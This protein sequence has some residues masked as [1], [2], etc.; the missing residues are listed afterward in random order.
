[1]LLWQFYFCI[2]MKKLEGYIIC[3]LI[4]IVVLLAISYRNIVVDYRTAIN[5]NKAYE[6]L[7]DSTK[8]NELQFKYT[9]KELEKSSSIYKVNFASAGNI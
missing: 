6:H 5:N 3:S 7:L 8:N 2:V 4:I 9:I 1:M